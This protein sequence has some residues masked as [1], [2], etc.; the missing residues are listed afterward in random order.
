VNIISSSRCA[1]GFPERI[2]ASAEQFQIEAG[3]FNLL[4]GG[5]GAGKSTILAT[6]ARELPLLSGVFIYAAQQG[7]SVRDR[8]GYVPQRV[9]VPQYLP[10]NV[11]EF[12]TLG[13]TRVTPFFKSFSSATLQKR[14]SLIEELGLTAIRHERVSMLS[15]GQLQRATIARELL[16]EPQLL[17]LDETTSGI[18]V[19]HQASVMRVIQ[20][21]TPTCAVLLAT[22]DLH[23]VSLPVDW[24]YAIDDEQLT[25]KSFEESRCC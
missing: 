25:K 3:T 4:L 12:V 22:H 11:D 20:S 7:V 10:M 15:V 16:G 14:D 21:I 13:A 18:D 5:N 17:L 6:L 24:V 9:I 8:I 1:F 2:V 19:K 23:H